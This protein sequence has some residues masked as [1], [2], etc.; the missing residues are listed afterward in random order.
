[1]S[2]PS[3]LSAWTAGGSSAT[4]R[5]PALVSRG[6]PMIKRCACSSQGAA[7]GC[8]EA[9]AAIDEARVDLHQARARRDLGASVFAGE[10][11]A[12]A[13]ERDFSAHG[14]GKLREHTRR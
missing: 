9:R 2:C 12:H 1:M 13:D 3:A 14:I 10:D 4:R 7:A 8:D 6:I 5:S 11:A